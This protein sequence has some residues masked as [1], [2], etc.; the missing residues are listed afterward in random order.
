MM[1]AA[2][3]FGEKAFRKLTRGRRKT[4]FNKAM[5]ESWAYALRNTTIAQLTPIKD[6]IYDSA[7]TLMADS[8]YVASIGTSTG[9]SGNVRRRFSAV[10]EIVERH[11]K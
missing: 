2:F 3:I 1:G 4:P 8:S 10:S 11:S 9:N 7:L 5:F 6:K